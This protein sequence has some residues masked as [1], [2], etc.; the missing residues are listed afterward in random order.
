[1][2]TLLTLSE[3]EQEPRAFLATCGEIFAEF[4][5]RTQ[6]SGNISYGLRTPD[7]E[8]YF[9]KTAG[10]PDDTR[11]TLT[12]PERV[13]ALRNG[14]RIARLIGHPALPRL[15]NVIE[16]AQGPLLV[17]EWRNGEMLGVAREERE[18]PDS[19]YQRFR[20]LPESEITDALDAVF[21]V[22]AALGEHDYIAYDFY[23]GSLLYDFAEHRLTLFDLDYY[24]QG[25]FTNTMGRMF[26][27]TRFMAPEE[28]KL[29]ATIDQRTTVFTMGR[30]L[31]TFLSDGTLDRQPFR[32]TD[33]QH[34]VMCHACEQQKEDRYPSVP[35]FYRAWRESIKK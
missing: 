1:M 20:H 3:T 17:Y 31:A 5:E 26:G 10:L 30:L 8:R 32:G 35:D 7:G 6:G 24:R 19:A 18:K 25:A 12:Y 33:A 13:S 34:R 4:G 28:F 14:E 22:H 2:S 21:T 9:V 27:S 15:W 29:G 16:S 11:W 23:D